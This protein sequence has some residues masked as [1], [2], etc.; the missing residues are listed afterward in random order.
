MSKAYD[1]GNSVS[2]RNKTISWIVEIWRHTSLADIRGSPTIFR[3]G[4]LVF[5]RRYG[6]LAVLRGRM[7]SEAGEQGQLDGLID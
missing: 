5:G 2:S 4:I 7:T 1:T 6:G 3:V